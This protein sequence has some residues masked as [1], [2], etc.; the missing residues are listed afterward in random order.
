LL[1]SISTYKSSIEVSGVN[2]LSVE[3][4][5]PPPEVITDK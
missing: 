2:Y 1:K 5:S 4:Y 3:A